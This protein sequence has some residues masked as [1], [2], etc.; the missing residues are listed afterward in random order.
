MEIDKIMGI[1]IRVT[2]IG[3]T[4]TEEEAMK[5]DRTMKIGSTLGIGEA[6]V[7]VGEASEGGDSAVGMVVGIETQ[8]ITQI[9]LPVEVR[10]IY[11]FF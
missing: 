8:N 9:V 7:G 11:C 10:A 3:V 1:V 2:V 6:G 5:T 4:I